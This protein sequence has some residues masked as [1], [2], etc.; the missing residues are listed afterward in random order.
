MGGNYSSMLCASYQLQCEDCRSEDHLNYQCEY[1]VDTVLATYNSSDKC[2]ASMELLEFVLFSGVGELLAHIRDIEE[3]DKALNMIYG[4]VHP[5][6]C[7]LQDYFHDNALI[8]DVHE[9]ASAAMKTLT[10]CRTQRK[11][12]M[13][14]HTTVNLLQPMV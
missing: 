9:R 2:H 11:K 7:Y 6:Y 13:R 4:E 10:F 1:N 14:M 8:K 3:E 5:I 12:K